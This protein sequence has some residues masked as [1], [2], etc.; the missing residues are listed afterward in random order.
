MNDQQFPKQSMRWLLLTRS[1]W[2]GSLK[3]KTFPV[4]S[5]PLCCPC[6][7]S[8]TCCLNPISL[9][10][11]PA[12]SSLQSQ[13]QTIQKQEAAPP[14]S[15]PDLPMWRHSA[16]HTAFQHGQARGGAPLYARQVDLGKLCSLPMH[17]QAQSDSKTSSLQNS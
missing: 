13:A 11:S 4:G 10:Q 16:R 9:S 5:R 17:G 7:M 1:C 12:I 14:T 6:A 8:P 15:Q 3:A 2:L